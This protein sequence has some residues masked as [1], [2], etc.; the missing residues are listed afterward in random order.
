M[1]LAVL[2]QGVAV[3]LPFICGCWPQ[4]Q[5]ISPGMSKMNAKLSSVSRAFEW[6]LIVSPTSHLSQNLWERTRLS[7]EVDPRDHTV[8]RVEKRSSGIGP[9]LFGIDNSL[10]GQSICERGVFDDRVYRWPSFTMP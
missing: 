2:R 4:K 3:I 8:Q 7:R 5:T 6:N 1:Q 10:F 9:S